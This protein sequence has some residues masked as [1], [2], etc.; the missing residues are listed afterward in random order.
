MY[1]IIKQLYKVA[2]IFFL[3]ITVTFYML[4][5]KLTEKEYK[6][7]YLIGTPKYN[8]IGDLAIVYAEKQFIKNINENIHIV[9]IPLSILIIDGN[10]LK[11]IIKNNDLII[12]HGGGNMG[13][14]YTKEEKCRRYFVSTFT[15][16]KIVIFPQ[17][18]DFSNTDK[19]RLELQ[20]TQKIY[21]NHPDL[22]LIAREKVS[23]ETM[24]QTFP[25]NNIILTPDIVLS[26]RLEAT[27]Q[28]NRKGSMNCLRSDIES[29]FDID[30]KT[31][32]QKWISDKFVKV[33]ITDTIA[34]EKLFRFTQ[35]THVIK[36][37]LLEFSSS[38]FVLTDR[39]HGMVF[40][41]IT[42]T[43][44]IAFSNYNH[45]VLGT[46]EWLKDLDYIAYGKDKNELDRLYS[47]LKVGELHDYDPAIFD[48]YWNKIRELL[49]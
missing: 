26:L 34:Y 11:K 4:I 19:G 43:P 17:T 32:L 33:N 35:K 40:S 8:N 49:K 41:A 47:Q 2:Y 45:K 27:N 42:G 20:E 13:D 15:K 44:C 23:Y 18:I 3:K 29:Q 22:T 28:R 30:D 16:N 21:S 38:E 7:M 12:G 31:Y 39:L 10:F 9:S 37:K 48:P 5:S 24:L 6:I 36:S 46:Y 25:N 14:E 1:T